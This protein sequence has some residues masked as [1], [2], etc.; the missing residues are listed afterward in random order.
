MKKKLN[1]IWSI[2]QVII[3]IFVILVTVF[4][5]CKNKY[6]YTEI[7]NYNFSYV[8]K[9]D[10]K[11]LKNINKNDLL[12]IKK[13]NSIKQG[14]KVFYYDVYKNDY[15]I[16]QA[17][18]VKIEESSYYISDTTSIEKSKIIG[19]SYKTIPKLGKLISF[20]ETK[21]GFI[22]FIIIPLVI[23]FIYQIYKF[24]ST[25]K[26]ERKKLE[27]NIST[28]SIESEE[29]NESGEEP[30]K[31]ESEESEESEKAD[32]PEESEKADEPEEEIEKSEEKEKVKE[33]PKKKK[34]SKS[35]TKTKTK[36]KDDIEIL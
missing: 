20:L 19:K 22:L 24:I 25:I 10:A 31:E 26:D 33:K 36:E 1:I 9:E 8:S 15:I 35:K 11:Y 21:K 3:I 16:R 27:E 17:N 18:I 13:N 32:E 5:L 4:V 23:I 6:G 12:I 34:K 14:N 2:I 7:A 30:V 28:E 29:L